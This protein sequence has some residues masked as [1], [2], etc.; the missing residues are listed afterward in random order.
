MYFCYLLIDF[1][2]LAL[3]KFCASRVTNAILLAFN[4]SVKNNILITRCGNN[5]IV[6]Y[7]HTAC[8]LSL[9]STLKCTPIATC[10]LEHGKR[11]R[12]GGEGGRVLINSETSTKLELSGCCFYI[13]FTFSIYLSIL[14]DPFDNLVWMWISVLYK[15][16]LKE[17]IML[18]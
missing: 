2:P 17:L 6:G 7:P 10:L 15:I 4:S 3:A 14:L 16:I 12:K 13:K 5:C 18:T 1:A 11:R 9:I 8:F